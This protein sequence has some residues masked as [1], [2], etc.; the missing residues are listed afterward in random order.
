MIDKHARNV[1]AAKWDAENTKQI[2]LKLNLRTDADI[3]EHLD[4]QESRQGYIKAL[5]RADIE[6]EDK[7][8][9]FT[10]YTEDGFCTFT[11]DDMGSLMM[12]KPD[13]TEEPYNEEIYDED[14]YT[15][16]RQMLIR[17]GVRDLHG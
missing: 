15:T 8:M 4:K 3:L 14:Q 6:K 10:G 7:K 9:T 13:G 16:I 17:D 11:L 5:I 12:T 2:K 1:T